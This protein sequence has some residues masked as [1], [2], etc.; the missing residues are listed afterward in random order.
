MKT[1]V[2]RNGDIQVNSGKLLF[3][4]GTTK[5]VEDITRWLQEPLGTGWTTPG[6]GSTLYAMIGTPQ[7]A[8]STNMVSTEILRVLQLYQGQQILDLRAAQNSAQLAYYSQDEVI[9]K[10]QDITVELGFN[11]ILANVSIETLAGNLVNL[12]VSIGN[13]G[14]TV[15]NG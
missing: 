4:K 15:T 1:L 3:A 6:F 7:T 13:N 8:A 11:S 14:V 12:S 5:L 2:V 10:V 9:Q